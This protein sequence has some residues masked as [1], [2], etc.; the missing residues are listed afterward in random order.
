MKTSNPNSR[1]FQWLAFLAVAWAFACLPKASAT[2]TNVD[3]VT[4]NLYSWAFVPAAV[5][6]NVHDSVKWTWKGYNHTTTSDVLLW[7]SKL[8]NTGWTYTNTFTSAGT[9]PY[10]CT[11]HY[12]TGLVTVQSPNSPPTVAITN[13]PNG[14]TL[15]A[16]AA[17]SLTAAAG[18][19]TGSVTNIQFFQGIISLGNGPNNPYTLPVTGLSAGDYTFSAVATDNGGLTATNAI[20]IHVVTPVTITLAAL[21]RPSSTIFQFNYSA[22]VGLR[23]VV[24]RSVDLTHWTGISTNAAASNPVIFQDDNASASLSFYRVGRLPNP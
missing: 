16:P 20:T 19:T 14:A 3:I 12:F 23:Y 9:F 2:L 1:L 24:E 4:Y 6:I 21:Q 22:N 5:T 10:S 13:P 15:S 18:D 8:H 7:D 17:L 11:Y